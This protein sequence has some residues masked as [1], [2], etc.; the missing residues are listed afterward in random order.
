[1][2]ESIINWQ[3]NG[4]EL[5]SYIVE[6]YGGGSFTKE[7][8]SE[9]YY[10]QPSITWSKIGSA[11]FGVRYSGTGFILAD[12]SSGAFPKQSEIVFFLGYLNSTVSTSILKS[13]APTLNFKSGDI[14]NLP[15]LNHYQELIEQFEQ[16][17]Q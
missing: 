7:I 6:R 11:N 9:E 14:A 8:R 15:V 1:M 12:A 16:Q 13:I 10:F 2:N 3:C 4:K 5:K 17:Q